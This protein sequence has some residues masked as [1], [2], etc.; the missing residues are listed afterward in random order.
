[1][2]VKKYGLRFVLALLII[3][4]LGFLVMPPLVKWLL[5]EQLAAALH[6]P[7]SIEGLRINPY[8]LSLQVDGLAIQ[9]TGGAE[10]VAGFDQLFIN[11][12]SSSLFRGGPVISELKLVGP[13]LSLVRLP[14][15]RFN[16][17]DLIDEFMA[18]PPSSGPTPRF[19]V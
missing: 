12:E 9:E 14:D 16:F 10:K 11:L 2:R 6:R 5:V 4:L 3:G 15:G 19:S 13:A 18:R 17:S 8:T 7:V 1:M